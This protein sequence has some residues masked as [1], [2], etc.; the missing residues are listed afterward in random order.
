MADFQSQAM[1]LTGLTIDGSSTYPSRVKFSQF[2]NDGVLDVTNKM[3][4]LDS[5]KASEFLRETTTSDSQDVQLDGARIVSIIREANAAD[6]WRECMIANPAHRSRLVDKDSLNFASIYN[7]K[8]ILTGD[9]KIS[10]FP[11]PSGNNGFKVLYV[12]NAPIDSDGQAVDHASTGLNFFPANKVYLVVIYA[13]IQSLRCAL[14][15]KSIPTISGDGTAP[16]ELTDVSILDSDNTIDVLADQGEF[17]QWWSTA[18]HMIE[19]EEDIELAGS[20]LQKIQTYIQA[21]S[22]QLQ[23]NRTEYEWM[24]MRYQ[25]LDQLYDKTFGLSGPREKGPQEQR[26]AE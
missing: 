3:I 9:G 10:V 26:R 5:T 15:A 17:D 1:G 7:P 19:D 16:R 12:N 11:A 4:A 13:S 21:Y 2:L 20:Q 18:G 6:E 22:T 23:G 25:F 14:A 8:Y 24:V